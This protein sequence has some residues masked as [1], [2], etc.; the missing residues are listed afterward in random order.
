VVA[1]RILGLLEL[2]DQ[3]LELLLSFRAISGPGFEGRGHGRDDLDVFSDYLLALL[4]FVQTSLD[5]S[6]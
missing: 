5:A 4:G 3:P 6:G 1:D 2:S